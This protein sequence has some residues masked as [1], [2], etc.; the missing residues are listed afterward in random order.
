MDFAAPHVGYVIASYGLSLLL[1]GGI[2]LWILK[3]NRQRPDAA[4]GSAK[5][6]A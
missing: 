2:A 4:P 1:L 6:D 5:G 3:R